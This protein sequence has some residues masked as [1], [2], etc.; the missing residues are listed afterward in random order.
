MPSTILK[1]QNLRIIFSITLMAVMGVAS[2]TPVFPAMREI[3][4]LSARQVGYLVTFF[5]LPGVILT[6]FFGILADRLG[7]KV[8]LIPSLFLFS[9]A[10]TACGFMESFTW[11]LVFRFIQGMGSAALG[12]I[13]ITLIGDLYEGRKRAE[14]MGYNASVL[15]VGTA[16]YPAIGGGLAT[17]AWY[18]PFLLP[19]L[20]LPVGL[21]VVCC[22]KNPEPE[23]GQKLGNYLSNT[24]KLLLDRQV[25]GLFILSVLTFIILYGSFLTY[26]PVMLGERFQA[27]AWQIGVL[28]SAS[29]IATAITSSML[30]RLTD[31]FSDLTLLVSSYILYVLAMVLIPF[32][33]GIWQVLIPALLFGMAQ[34]I[35]IP[36]LM[37]I[38]SGLAPLKYR[39]IFMSINGWVLR[40]GQTLGPLIIGAVYLAGGTLWAF[41]AGA[42]VAVLMI[43]IVVFLVG[44]NAIARKQI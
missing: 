35:N 23:K 8:V 42:M 27:P 3:F 7:R 14:A 29:S 26:L 33:M 2:L 28:M 41:L 20:A 44:G 30:G 17:M 40:I 19:A 24:W 13:N 9:I 11:L 31:R 37:N 34:G 32:V 22:L 6:P 5:T 15:S 21:W 12:S 16:V 25:L 43:V 4:D 39:A 1:D 10:G 36:G 18:Y 38:L